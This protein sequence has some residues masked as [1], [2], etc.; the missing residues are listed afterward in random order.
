MKLDTTLPW[1]SQMPKFSLV[2][3]ARNSQKE[4]EEQPSIFKESFSVS[5]MTC[6]LKQVPKM[7]QR[8]L[9]QKNTIS[10]TVL[11]PHKQKW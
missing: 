2:N 4:K 11:T 10:E 5:K 1:D 8:Q 9:F 6:N 3:Q 7:M